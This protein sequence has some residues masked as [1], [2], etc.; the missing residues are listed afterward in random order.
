MLNW[1]ESPLTT[2]SGKLYGMRTGEFRTEAYEDQNGAGPRLFDT[3]KI[4]LLVNEML[5]CPVTYLI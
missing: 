4:A 2:R 5:S 1:P 3:F